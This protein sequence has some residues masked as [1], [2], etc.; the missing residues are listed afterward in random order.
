M[1]EDK[2]RAPKRL[3]SADRAIAV[4]GDASP[5]GAQATEVLRAIRRIV[6]RVAEHS[7]YLSRE[8]GL[9]VPQLLCL[10]AI[11]ELEETSNPHEI[12]VAMVAQAVHLGPP[13]VSRIVD[14]LERARLV[15]RQRR[16]KDRRKVCLSLTPAGTERF[17]TLPEPLQETFVTRFDRLPERRRAEI[18]SALHHVIDMMEAGELDAAPVLAPGMDVRDGEPPGD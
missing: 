11:G 6:R 3:D 16:A 12:T 13:T 9:T 10:K 15:I 8:V 2:R 4:A 18:L 1:G 7:S 5:S 17:Q 14:R